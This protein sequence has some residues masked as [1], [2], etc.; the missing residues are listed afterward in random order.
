ME[1]EDDDDKPDPGLKGLSAEFQAM[2]GGLAGHTASF[3]KVLEKRSKNIAMSKEAEQKKDDEVYLQSYGDLA[4]HEDM[5][6][7]APRVQ[8]YL[9]AIEHY[10]AEWKQRG[11]V[12]VVDVGSG[13]GL[14]AVLAARAGAYRVLAVE[15]SPLSVYLRQVVG[16]NVAAG[17]VEVHEC[18][19]ENL[20]LGE[21]KVVDV[22]VS[23]WMGYF[24]LFENMLP[25]VLSVRDRYL[26]P[27]GMMLPSRSRLLLSPLQDGAWRDGKVGFW[28]NVSGIDMSCLMP[29]ATV[30]AC[31]KPQHRA[32][33]LDGLFGETVEILDLDL[34]AVKVADLRRFDAPLRI[35]VPP[36][37][38]LDGFAS[39]FDC[40]FG[41]AG[42]LLSTAPS[43]PLTHWRQTAFYL[44][45]P[46]EGGASG[47]SVTGSVV[48]EQLEDYTRGYRVTFEL[49]AP[50][51][52]QRIESFELR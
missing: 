21:D 1:E 38:R 29:L 45:Q 18:L 32:V 2:V 46:L 12:T 47:L 6:K 30:T 11:D 31:E 49:S 34:L 20:A 23:E 43:K 4:I 39:W 15:A 52:K 16:A 19:A 9:Q 28:R 51:R 36:G 48:V 24:L 14:L 35:E 37:G 42:R 41:T 22:I 8:A 44:R 17:T 33:P 40:D 7:D 26:K 13:T 27:G 3:A 10:S 5:L 50:A 25:S